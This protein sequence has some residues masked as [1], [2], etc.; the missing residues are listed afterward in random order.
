MIY[1]PWEIS[2]ASLD[3]QKV[4]NGPHALI[5]FVHVAEWTIGWTQSQRTRLY[6]D[7]VPPIVYLN[8]STFIQNYFKKLGTKTVRDQASWASTGTKPQWYLHDP[9]CFPV[10]FG[11]SPAPRGSS[12][13]HQRPARPMRQMRLWLMSGEDRTP[14]KIYIE[15]LSLPSRNTF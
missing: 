1:C 13:P 9:T 12:K 11:G 5:K 7:I 3:H 2:F 6:T 10:W 8:M 14:S 4:H 15:I